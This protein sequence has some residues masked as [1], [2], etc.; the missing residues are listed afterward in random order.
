MV[1]WND[2]RFEHPNSR[3]V[4]H[5]PVPQLDSQ[6]EPDVFWVK[7]RRYFDAHPTGAD[8]LLAIEVADTSLKTKRTTKAD[9]YA[10]AGIQE[11]WVVDI[12][13]KCIYQMR[14]VATDGHYGWQRTVRIGESISPLAQQQAELMISDLFGIA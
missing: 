10:A 14:E 13:R 5:R 12:Q 8:T 11:Y 4:G 6:P 1:L 3:S 2:E 7:A 9:L